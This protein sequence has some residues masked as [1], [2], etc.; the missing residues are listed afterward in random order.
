MSLGGDTEHAQLSPLPLGSQR[1][2]REH[3]SF[4]LTCRKVPPPATCPGMGG[5]REGQS[6]YNGWHCLIVRRAS[7]SH[8]LCS[9]LSVTHLNICLEPMLVCQWVT[10][11]FCILQHNNSLKTQRLKLTI[12]YLL[13]SHLVCGLTRWF[14]CSTRCQP[15]HWTSCR[16]SNVSIHMPG[17]WCWL[18][19]GAVSWGWGRGSPPHVCLGFLLAW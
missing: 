16:V 3:V 11:E 15:Q 18:L 17:I 2:Y 1:T 14:F 4:A 8:I 12:Y 5:R 13:S 6:E 9:T 10:Y 19:A 7:T